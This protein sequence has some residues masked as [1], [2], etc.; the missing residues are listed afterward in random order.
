MNKYIRLII[1]NCICIFFINSQ[2]WSN[3]NTSDENKI[4]NGTYVYDPYEKINR[5]ILKFN[6]VVDDIAIQPV[7]TTYKAITPDLA[8]KGISNFF[9]NIKEPLKS[10]TFLIQ[11]DIKKS[12]NSIGRFVTN[13]T[14]SLGFY[15]TSK[16]LGLKKNS[17]DMGTVIGKAG[18]SSGPYLVIPIIGPTN[19]RDFTGIILDYYIDP[20]SALK[21]NSSLNISATSTFSTRAEYDYEINDLKKNSNDLYNSIKLLYH[22]RRMGAI[23]EDHLRNLPVPKIYID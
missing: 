16:H 2:L 13:S 18:V 14:T 12:I 1:V 23:D 22:Q 9:S 21:N 17:I 20:I 5:S 4:N 7:V 3:E 11:G 19:M 15:D 6:I 8:E 10:I